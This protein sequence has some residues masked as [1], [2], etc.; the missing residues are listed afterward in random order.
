[1]LQNIVVFGCNIISYPQKKGG[2]VLR[3]LM[4][5]KR[6][7]AQGEIK[8]LTLPKEK[9]KEKTINDAPFPPMLL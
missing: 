5:L 6:G 9:K 1:M 2:L 4:F 3:V 8:K 7:W